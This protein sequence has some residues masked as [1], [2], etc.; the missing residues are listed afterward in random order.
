MDCGVSFKR[1]AAWPVGLGQYSTICRMSL[2]EGYCIPY[3]LLLPLKFQLKADAVELHKSMNFL[4]T[5]L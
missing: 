4:L 5:S 3:P 1:L 2:P